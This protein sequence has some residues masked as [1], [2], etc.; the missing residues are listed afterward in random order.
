MM[1]VCKYN[2][3]LIRT[4]CSGVYNSLACAGSHLCKAIGPTRS[5]LPSLDSV[6][7]VAGY[8]KFR[9]EH[10]MRASSFLQ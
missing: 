4:Q 5:C 2:K 3:F 7:T 6:F 1:S 8:Q 10:P 9:T